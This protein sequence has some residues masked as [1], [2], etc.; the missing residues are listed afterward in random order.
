MANVLGTGPVGFTSKTGAHLVIPLSALTLNSD[1]SVSIAA[2]WPKAGSPEDNAADKTAA[3]DWLNYLAREGNFQTAV[4]S[5]AVPPSPAFLATAVHPGDAAHNKVTLKIDNVTPANPPSVTIYQLDVTVENTYT[6][7]T[8]DTLADTI[9]TAVDGGNKPGLVHLV[10]PPAPP[11]TLLPNDA[12]T[13]AFDTSAPAQATLVGAGPA[14]AFV[15]EAPDSGGA[16]A[17]TAAVLNVVAGKTFDLAV[18]WKK[19]N[20]GTGASHATAFAS[21]VTI[22]KPAGGDYGIPPAGTFTLTGGCDPG[23]TPIAAIPPQ[24]TIPSA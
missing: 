4:S 5:V 16:S 7:L 8:L 11:P 9:G 3:Q 12:Q 20:T 18:T 24:A 22:A 15:L 2:S 13:V 19:S 6:G 23:S 1:S 10:T 17:F 21:V 14:T